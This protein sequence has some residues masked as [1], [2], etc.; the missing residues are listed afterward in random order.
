[1]RPAT[2]K[3][4]L[5]ANSTRTP[6]LP[7][8]RVDPAVPVLPEAAA[9]VVPDEEPPVLPPASLHMSRKAMI[10]QDKSGRVIRDCVR[11][12]FAERNRGQPESLPGRHRFQRWFS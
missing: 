4:A 7:L 2:P 8:P 12:Y 3:R 5:P 11:T 10:R 6:E 1:M 9:V